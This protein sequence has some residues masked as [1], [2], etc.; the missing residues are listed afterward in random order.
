MLAKP[1]LPLAAMSTLNKN[2]PINGGDLLPCF[3]SLKGPQT[4]TPSQLWMLSKLRFSNWFF[5]IAH[6]PLLAFTEFKTSWNDATTFLK[7]LSFLSFKMSAKDSM[8]NG[9]PFSKAPTHTHET[10]PPSKTRPC[11][12]MNLECTMLHH[13]LFERNS[14]CLRKTHTE[15]IND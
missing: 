2:N 9:S 5:S 3:L 13:K 14:K 1:S 15:E 11:H 4:K 12:V 6:L 8:R 7:I 10:G